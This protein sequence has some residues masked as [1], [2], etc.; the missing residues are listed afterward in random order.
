MADMLSWRSIDDACCLVGCY[1][2]FVRFFFSV[3]F[4]PFS[5]VT[6]AYTRVEA[7]FKPTEMSLKLIK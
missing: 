6:A 7:S 2:V 5:A 4:K 3:E 1:L